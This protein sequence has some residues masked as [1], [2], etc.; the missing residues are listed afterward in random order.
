MVSYRHQAPFLLLYWLQH[1]EYPL[2]TQFFR[3]LFN[4]SNF[5]LFLKGFIILFLN[6][7]CHSSELAVEMGT[8]LDLIIINWISPLD[9]RYADLI[10]FIL[11]SLTVFQKF[12]FHVFFVKLLSI[13]YTQ[14]IQTAQSFMILAG[15]S[16]KIA[17]VC[18]A[19]LTMNC[20]SKYCFVGNRLSGL[21]CNTSPGA[22]PGK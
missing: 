13:L 12:H 20:P 9:T 4:D 17:L 15:S 8:A 16:S 5:Q 19:F 11:L 22:I 14:N 7:C 3:L 6:H 21:P 18:F 2:S 1:V 10:S